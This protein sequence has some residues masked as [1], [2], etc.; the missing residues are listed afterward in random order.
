VLRT[1]TD[2][3]AISIRSLAPTCLDGREEV[4]RCGVW[5]A[6]LTTVV[7]LSEI[8]GS[9]VAV[10]LGGHRAA[11]PIIREHVEASDPPRLTP[12]VVKVFASDDISVGERDDGLISVA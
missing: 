2:S 11:D 6:L 10:F 9:Y 8:V 1:V 3:S 5:V 4:A 7:M 12:P